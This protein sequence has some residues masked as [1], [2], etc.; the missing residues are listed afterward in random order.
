M[1]LRGRKGRYDRLRR[2]ASVRYVNPFFFGTGERRL[3][4]VYTP[5]QRGSAGVRAAVLCNP[6]GQ[7][8]LRAHRSMRQLAMQLNRAGVHVLRFDYFGTGDSGGDFT[9]GDLAGWQGDVDTAIEELKDATGATRVGLVGLRLGATLAAAVAARRE[10]VERLLLWDPI[11]DGEEYVRE[12]WQEP[13]QAR[14]PEPP[15]AREV[16][17]FVLTEDMSRELRS[18]DLLELVPSFPTRTLVVASESL[19]SHVALQAALDSPPGG[20]LPMERI[21]SPRAWLEEQNTGIGAVP[22][23]M[24]QRIVEWWG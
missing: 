16:L 2:H 15:G 8:Y 22:V 17:G 1:Q 7:E 18:L 9:D 12:L 4:G 11:V 13:S 5:G 6:W 24:L 10:D 21:A 20:P 3:F 14:S 19:P 23:K